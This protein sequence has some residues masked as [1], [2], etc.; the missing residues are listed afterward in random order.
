M[1]V[2]A[3]VTKAINQFVQNSAALGDETVSLAALSDA[4]DTLILQIHNTCDVNLSKQLVYVTNLDTARLATDTIEINE[5]TDSLFQ[6]NRSDGEAGS[7]S[8]SSQV[9]TL[10]ASATKHIML[11]TEDNVLL[12]VLRLGNASDEKGIV[13]VDPAVQLETSSTRELPTRDTPPENII[14]KFQALHNA[15]QLVEK[16]SKLKVPPTT[17]LAVI[18]NHLMKALSAKHLC[19]YLNHCAPSLDA[20]IGQLYLLHGFKTQYGKPKLQ[21]EYSIT[22]AYG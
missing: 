2:S 1:A 16:K 15:P 12:D 22:P 21:V 5:S 3:E 20:T 8:F 6:Y 4:L 11:K 17:T 10:T 7:W 14:L 19:I 13:Y 9:E 18:Q